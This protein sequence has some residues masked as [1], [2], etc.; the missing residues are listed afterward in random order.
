MQINDRKGN[1]HAKNIAA[2][3]ATIDHLDSRYSS[4]RGKHYGEFRRVAACL[5]CNGKRAKV[6][7][8]NIPIEERRVRAQNGHRKADKIG[9]A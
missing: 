8:S 9:A 1:C 7:Q 3:E 2:N 5:E 4:E 6:E